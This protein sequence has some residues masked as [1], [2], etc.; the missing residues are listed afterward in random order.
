MKLLIYLFLI[1]KLKLIHFNLIQSKFIK[2]MF[3]IWSYCLWSQTYIRLEEKL[4]CGAAKLQSG[5]SVAC[6]ARV[7]SETSLATVV[8]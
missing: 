4:T 2:K 7:E 5:G 6:L 3:L 8:S 1:I